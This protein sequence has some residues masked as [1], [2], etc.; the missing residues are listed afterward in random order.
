MT[1]NFAISIN[2]Q[3]KHVILCHIVSTSMVVVYFT[4]KHVP[5]KKNVFNKILIFDFLSH[6]PHLDGKKQKK[7]V[8]FYR[9]DLIYS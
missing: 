8:S 1:N 6:S 5:Q 4:M 2:F 7:S 9:F 3:A